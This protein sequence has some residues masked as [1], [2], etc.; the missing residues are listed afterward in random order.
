MQ[1]EPRELIYDLYE[2]KY[3]VDYEKDVRFA[4][5]ITGPKFLRNYKLAK[6]KRK[7]VDRHYRNCIRKAEYYRDNV[8]DFNDLKDFGHFVFAMEKSFFYNNDKDYSDVF[9]S[10]ADNGKVTL[11]FNTLKHVK[12][13]I[14]I[15]LY[16]EGTDE[17]TDLFIN[18]DYG[19]KLKNHH[20]IKNRVMPEDI[21]GNET[22]MIDTVNRVIQDAM[23]KMMKLYADKIYNGYIYDFDGRKYS[24][25][26]RNRYQIIEEWQED[27]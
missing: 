27:E 9:G 3:V 2:A 11:I 6:V 19:R 15:E 22:I 10:I 13:T 20:Y 7:N 21:D 17:I 18:R 1:G 16:Y 8:P 23:Y 14:K 4:D 26:R 12:T 24:N 5:E 25:D